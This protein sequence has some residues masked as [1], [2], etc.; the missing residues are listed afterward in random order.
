MNIVSV[1]NEPSTVEPATDNNDQ[2]SPAYA[3]QPGEIVDVFIGGTAVGY[4]G[5]NSH[6]FEVRDSFGERAFVHVPFDAA[7]LSITR[8]VPAD[9]TPQPGEV[10]ITQPGVRLFAYENGTAANRSTWL[11][12]PTTGTSKRWHEVHTGD[13]GPIRRLASVDEIGRWS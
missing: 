5:R 11:M 10:W 12:D 4:G 6:V 9:G 8:S 13:A 1:T 3:F 7:G 2:A